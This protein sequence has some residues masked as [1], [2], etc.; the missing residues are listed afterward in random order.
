MNCMNVRKGK[1]G[2]SKSNEYVIVRWCSVTGGYT[3]STYVLLSLKN[4]FG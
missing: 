1:T 3:N 4:I 2:S